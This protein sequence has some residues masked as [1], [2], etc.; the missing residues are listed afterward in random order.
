MIGYFKSLGMSEAEIA[1]A[2]QVIEL[3]M[4]AYDL[5][6]EEVF[7]CD[8]VTPEGVR[9]F[10]SIWIF[11]GKRV[12]E[13]GSFMTEISIDLVRIEVIRRVEH[14]IS[15]FDFKKASN[16]SSMHIDVSINDKLSILLNAT[17]DNCMNLDRLIRKYILPH[18]A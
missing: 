16:N 2:E 6:R 1:R 11:D 15:N 12:A 4:L 5:K 18:L 13:I 3:C 10:T 9:K 7:V 8:V 17:G 14:K